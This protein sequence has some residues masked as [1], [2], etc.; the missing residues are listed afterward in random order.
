MTAPTWVIKV[1]RRRV[2]AGLTWIPLQAEKG[3]RSLALTELR[4]RLRNSKQ[5]YGLLDQKVGGDYPLAG[6]PRVPASEA[7]KLSRLP[8]IATW[9]ARNVEE[10]VIY[11]EKVGERYWLLAADRGLLDVR[12]DVLLSQEQ[13]RELIAEM[14][15]E[16]TL[17]ARDLAQFIVAD[18]VVAADFDLFEGQYRVQPLQDLLQGEP[19]KAR[20]EKMLG[21]PNVVIGVAGVALA[22]GI[23]YYGYTKTSEL[24]LNQQLEKDRIAREAADQARRSAMDAEN[25][26]NA[27]KAAAQ[28]LEHVT[29]TPSPHDFVRACLK[30]FDSAPMALLTWPRARSVCDGRT[31]RMDYNQNQDSVATEEQVQA[32]AA[33]L[34]L[35][36]TIDWL[37]TRAVVEV[38]VETLI[39]RDPIG[40]Q[41]LSPQKLVGTAL[42]AVQLQTKR[43]YQG[44]SLMAPAPRAEAMPQSG[45][46][47]VP[48]VFATSNIRLSGPGTWMVL[49]LVPDAR[50]LTLTELEVV[51][52]NLQWSATGN[53]VT[54]LQ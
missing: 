20:V 22:S 34:G 48:P 28:A 32:R 35:T 25:K 14:H 19:S 21:V 26:A 42:G 39:N 51:G 49:D 50:W 40:A 31:M 7:A 46:D 52:T 11:L 44:A 53:V 1:G 29:V 6:I 13:A 30:A 10:T 18:D 8:A 47:V 24:L 33:E 15:E 3:K 4:K 37:G 43:M 36:A 27:A 38:P 23:T 2:V 45:K 5:R 17:N 54:A 41:D 16:S 12:T 9:F